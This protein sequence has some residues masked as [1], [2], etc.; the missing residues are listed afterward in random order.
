MTWE[1]IKI[2]TLQKMFA[3]DG[4]AI[5]NDSATL[6]YVAAMPH[7]ANE[8]LQLLA[9]S[10]KF[11]LKK[12][13]IAHTPIDNLLSESIS[14]PVHKLVSGSEE[15]TYSG[16]KSYYLE[17]YGK[18]T[19]KIYVDSVLSETITLTSP[20]K[21]TAYKGLISNT[22]KEV[23]L[24]I[25][26]FFPCAF[27]NVAMY[28]ATF[29]TATDVQSFG[30]KIKYDVK[31][32]VE[33]FYM[34]DNQEVYFEGDGLNDSRYLKMSDFLQEGTNT[35]VIDRNRPGAYTF[36]YKAYPPQITQLTLDAYELPLDSE[37]AVLLPLYM[38]SAL[39]RDDDAGAAIG[40][41]NEFEI[42]RELLT[43]NNPATS[44]EKFVSESGW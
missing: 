21:F 2:A 34:F 27:K 18:G 44:S 42:A 24:E 16:A 4:N 6:N 3:T 19:L 13:E 23:K 15:F 39:Y 26:C 40:Y 29:E 37:V 10:G 36:Y 33:D 17:F 14:Y 5:G 1:E 38:A 30:E 9:T 8:A 20:T 28:E 11:I 25:S 32:I 31:S 7:V 41:R 12:F 22:D 43:G 35:I